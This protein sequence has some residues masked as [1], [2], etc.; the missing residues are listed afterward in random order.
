MGMNLISSLIKDGEEN[1]YVYDSSG[2]ASIGYC[3]CKGN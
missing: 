1:G 3:P 2:I